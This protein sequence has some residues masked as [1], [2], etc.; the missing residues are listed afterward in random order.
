MINIIKDYSVQFIKNKYCMYI[1]ILCARA[2]LT[3]R[4]GNLPSKDM[5]YNEGH[6]DRT[7][8]VA[9]SMECTNVYRRYPQIIYKPSIFGSCFFCKTVPRNCW[10][11]RQP[12]P[13]KWGEAKKFP[14]SPSH[15]E[16]E[17]ALQTRSPWNHPRTKDKTLTGLTSHPNKAVSF[18]LEEGLSCAYAP[19][20]ICKMKNGS[21]NVMHQEDKSQQWKQWNELHRLP[22]MP[23]E[24]LHV[25]LFGQKFGHS[26]QKQWPKAPEESKTEKANQM[27]EIRSGSFPFPA[28][29]HLLP[30][31]ANTWIEGFNNHANSP[32]VLYVSYCFM[33]FSQSWKPCLWIPMQTRQNPLENINW[34]LGL[35]WNLL[36]SIRQQ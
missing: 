23:A 24:W 20:F 1:Y 29:K 2:Q 18:Q 12:G 31:C 11:A 4:P 21:C 33:L 36:K 5:L 22:S 34:N 16:E 8:C 27:E 25:L 3:C 7:M 9:C 28:S 26:H 30:T 14:A 13:S 35:P 32:A 15:V 6:L 10:A 17:Q 19:K